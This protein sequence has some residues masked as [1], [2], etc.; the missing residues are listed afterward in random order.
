MRATDGGTEGST[1][2]MSGAGFVRMSIRTVMADLL[3]NT[4]RPEMRWKSVAPRE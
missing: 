2:V 4:G 3:S 1:E